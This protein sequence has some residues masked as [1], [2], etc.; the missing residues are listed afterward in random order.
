MKNLADLADLADMCQLWTLG[1]CNFMKTILDTCHVVLDCYG[2]PNLKFHFDLLLIHLVLS[3]RGP[4]KI[5]PVTLKSA[6]KCFH[7]FKSCTWNKISSLVYE[8]A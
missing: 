3:L 4:K 5:L 2:T 8:K 1:W 6:K 7:I